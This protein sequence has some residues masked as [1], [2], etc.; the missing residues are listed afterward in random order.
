MSRQEP[1]FPIVGVGASAG[2]VEALEGFFQ[3]M[4]DEPGLGI[5]I[6]THLNPERESLLHEIIARHTRPDSQKGP[7]DGAFCISD[8]KANLTL[9]P[10]AEK[11]QQRDENVDEVEIEAQRAH[12]GAAAKGCFTTARVRI[13]VILEL[14]GVVSCQTRED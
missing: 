5:V 4:V 13:I 10:V 7:V 8:A 2:G 6:V 14:L 9:P 12:D 11:L 1:N 3:G